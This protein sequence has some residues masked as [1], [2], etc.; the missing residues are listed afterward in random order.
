M[1]GTILKSILAATAAL[2]LS[3]A[4]VLAASPVELKFAVPAPPSS[5]VNLW[6][7]TPWSKKVEQDAKGTV[8]IK[9][10]PGATLG[11]FSNIYERTVA[12]VT[13]MA[14]GIFGPL[15]TEFRKVQVAALPFEAKDTLEA[16]TA[17][18]R[19]YDSGL[20]ADEF[21]KVKVLALFA[22]PHAGIHANKPVRTVE[23]LKGIKIVTSTRSMGQLITALGGSPMSSTPTE[24]Y[25]SVSRRVAD[26]I[27]VGWSA[28]KSFKLYEV[29]NFHLETESG[30]FTAYMLMNKNSYARLPDAA[31]RAIDRHS[32]KL[33]FEEMSRITDRLEQ[34]G[35]AETAALPGQTIVSL[36]P[37]EAARWKAAAK[38][39]VDEWVRRTPNGAKILAAFRKE[40]EK[41]RAGK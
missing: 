2:A 10:F 41:I 15:A 17:L 38:P 29:T 20:L 7:V 33:F 25:M 14:F 22:F 3:P 16:G 39:I 34:E 19:L 23:D 6:G 26:G 32:G 27:A 13:D 24:Y 8:S 31:K 36:A 5:P 12:G 21:S 9:V 4:N 40:I 30:L 11:N 1:H 35:R 28:V 37:A 18:W